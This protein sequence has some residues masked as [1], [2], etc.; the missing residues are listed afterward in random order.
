MEIREYNGQIIALLQEGDDPSEFAEKLL[1]LHKENPRKILISLEVT[2][3]ENLL[4]QIE[5]RDPLDF[6]NLCDIAEIVP[7]SDVHLGHY[8]G[9][10]NLTS[11]C[12]VP[13]WRMG[14]LLSIPKDP[15]KGKGGMPLKR[16]KGRFR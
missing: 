2:S 10:R 8:N 16:G 6:G 5:S 1:A 3:F 11:R 9:P 7:R 13:R 4:E 15:N 12:I 14:K